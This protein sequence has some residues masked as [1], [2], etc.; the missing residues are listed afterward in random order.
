MKNKII[1]AVKWVQ[2]NQNGLFKIAVLLILLYWTTIFK[3][4][5][6]NSYDL[7]WIQNEISNVS[8]SLD[9]INSTLLNR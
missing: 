3:N 5:A 8:K 7:T 9:D 4:I 2:E 1:Q 6:D